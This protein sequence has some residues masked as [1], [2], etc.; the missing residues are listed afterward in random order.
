MEMKNKIQRQLDYPSKVETERV[1]ILTI[2]QDLL[3]MRKSSQSV[4]RVLQE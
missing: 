2:F 3:K 1:S 4:A